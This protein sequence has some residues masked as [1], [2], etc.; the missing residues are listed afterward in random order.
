MQRPAKLSDI[1]ET[2]I[3]RIV[4][5]EAGDMVSTGSSDIGSYWIIV[6]HGTPPALFIL[7]LRCACRFGS[8]GP[9]DEFW[10]FKRIRGTI[11]TPG[12]RWPTQR[13]IF[14]PRNPTDPHYMATEHRQGFSNT[15]PNQH[16]NICITFIPFRYIRMSPE[17]NGTAASHRHPFTH[18]SLS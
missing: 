3:I 5:N 1:A 6:R 17:R 2:V 13:P 16:M 11:A 15:P 10:N 7:L 18:P 9:R 8:L 14:R 12:R 4:T